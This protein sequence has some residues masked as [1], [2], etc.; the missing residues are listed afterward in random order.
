MIRCFDNCYV[1]VLLRLG[2]LSLQHSTSLNIS[3]PRFPFPSTIKTPL[4]SPKINT[5][6][7]LSKIHQVLLSN[8]SSSLSL[9]SNS[10]PWILLKLSLNPR[11]TW[12]KLQLELSR[13]RNYPQKRTFGTSLHTSD[14]FKTKTIKP[15]SLWKFHRG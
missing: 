15:A 13:N 3:K 1:M 14:H 8:K 6:F 7:S 9:T 5:Q 12:G 2:N 10:Y 11:L 4:I